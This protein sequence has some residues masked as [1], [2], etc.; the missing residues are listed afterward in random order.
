MS[1]KGIWLYASISELLYHQGVSLLGVSQC[2]AWQYCICVQLYIED[3]YL[4]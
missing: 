1:L 3:S 4:L 2:S